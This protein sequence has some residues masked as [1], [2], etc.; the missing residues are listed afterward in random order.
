[1]PSALVT[2]AT[3]LVGSHIIERLVQD[4]WSVRALVRSRSPWLESVGVE[5]VGGDVLYNDAFAGA[6]AGRDVIF[7]TAA[8][9][10]PRV[11]A[12]AAPAVAAGPTDSA[13][14]KAGDPAAPIPQPPRSAAIATARP[15]SVSRVAA[16]RKRPSSVTRAAT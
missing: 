1:M 2:G 4:G 12:A 16:D 15:A 6:A 13:G 8:A 14:S 5:S 11:C 3:G 9:I 7:H 10:T